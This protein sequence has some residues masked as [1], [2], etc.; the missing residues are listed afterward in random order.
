MTREAIGFAG[1]ERSLGT[2]WD[3]GIGAEGRTWDE[4]HRSDRSTVG[5]V[6]HLT[7]ATRQRGRVLRAERSRPACTS[8]SRSRAP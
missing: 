6:A 3:L 7:A 1:I 5:A 2:G 8:A 4:P